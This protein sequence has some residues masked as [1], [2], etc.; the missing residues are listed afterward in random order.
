[1]TQLSTKYTLSPPTHTHTNHTTY[2]AIDKINGIQV[3]YHEVTPT[4]Q[5][6]YQRFRTQLRKLTNCDH[7]SVVVYYDY[8]VDYEKQV[9]VYTTEVFEEGGCER[10]GYLGMVMV[11]MLRGGYVSKGAIRKWC[12]QIIDGLVYMHRARVGHER[13][14]LDKLWVGVDGVKIAGD[15]GSVVDCDMDA[16]E[17]E[18]TFGVAICVIQLITGDKETY[19]LLFNHSISYL[20][21]NVCFAFLF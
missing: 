13:V 6:T 20:L 16:C 11:R 2:K 17:C 4:N 5:Y 9:M 15:V 3:A 18:D 19:D 10:Y 7:E 14:M 21:I 1:M 8:D 12:Y